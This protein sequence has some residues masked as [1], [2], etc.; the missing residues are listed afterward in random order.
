MQQH[1]M[2]QHDMQQHDM[3]QHMDW[4]TEHTQQPDMHHVDVE[5]HEKQR[6]Q[7]HEMRQ[8]ST[9]LCTGQRLHRNNETLRKMIQRGKGRFEGKQG[10]HCENDIKDNELH[11][12]M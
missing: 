8:P 1:D 12:R 6:H 7:H 11:T 9:C 5:Q 3:Q 4:F 2:Q 10:W